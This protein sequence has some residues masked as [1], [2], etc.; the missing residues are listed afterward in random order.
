MTQEPQSCPEKP[1]WTAEWLPVSIAP[2]DGE[3]LE[4]CVMDY[5]GII[6]ALTYA[7][8]EAGPDRSTLQ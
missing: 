6:L 8:T 3:D 1:L 7:F 2:S 4:L 5:D